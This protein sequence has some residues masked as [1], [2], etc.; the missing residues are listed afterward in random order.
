MYYFKI[1]TL[2]VTDFAHYLKIGHKGTTFFWNTQIFEQ[3]FL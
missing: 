1:F 3:H 2:I